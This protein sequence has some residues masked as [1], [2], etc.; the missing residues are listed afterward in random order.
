MGWLSEMDMRF[1][2]EGN[3]KL[4]QQANIYLQT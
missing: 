4:S 1:I 3:M 2:S